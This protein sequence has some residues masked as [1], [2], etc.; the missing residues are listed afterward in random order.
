MRKGIKAE[1]ENGSHRLVSQFCVALFFDVPIRYILAI[2]LRKSFQMEI[3][4]STFLIF[5]NQ[6]PGKR[7][8][9]PTLEV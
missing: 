4:Q 8:S 7:C 6:R 1:I 2:P 3:F 5:P 9:I